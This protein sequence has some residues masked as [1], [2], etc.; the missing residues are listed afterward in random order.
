MKNKEYLILIVGIIIGVVIGMLIMHFIYIYS[1]EKLLT[2]SNGIF[3]NMQI[4]FN[5]T[6]MVDRIMEIYN[7]TG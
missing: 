7:A 1:I 3:Q 6:K 2:A 5:E 4:N